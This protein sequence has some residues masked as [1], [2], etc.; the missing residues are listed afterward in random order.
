[1]ATKRFLRGPALPPRA[2]VIEGGEQRSH[3]FASLI[4]NAPLPGASGKLTNP[5]HQHPWLHGA[6]RKVGQMLGAVPFIMVRDDPAAETTRAEIGKAKTREE[7]RFLQARLTAIREASPR[8]VKD[9]I[10]AGVLRA[11]ETPVERVPKSPFQALFD[12]VNPEWSRLELFQA[13]VIWLLLEGNTVWILTGKGSSLGET[14]V[15]REIW[16][17][18]REGWKV[19]NDEKTGEV[20]EWVRTVKRGAVVE[21]QR[22]QPHE[23]IHFRAFDPDVPFFS[24]SPLKAAWSSMEQDTMAS[25]WNRSYFEN[26]AEPGVT[27]LLPKEDKS[28]DKDIATMR[29][30]WEDRHEGPGKRNRLAILTGGATLD[31]PPATHKDMEFATLLDKNR[32]AILA[33]IGVHKA[34]LGVTDSLNRATIEEANRMIWSN[35]LAPTAAYIEDRLYTGLFSRFDGGKTYG[36]F[37]LSAVRELQ[38]DLGTK[39]DTALKYQEL[40]VPLN[41]ANRLLQLGLPDYP[42]GD[43]VLVDMGKVPIEDV[44]DPLGPMGAGGNA[45]AAADD[46]GDDAATIDEDGAGGGNA[47]AAAGATL[48]GVQIE[49]AQNVIANLIAGQIPDSVAIELLVALGFPRDRAE[50]MVA[51]AASFEPADKPSEGAPPPPPPKGDKGEDAGSDGEDDEG[52]AVRRAVE[53]TKRPDRRKWWDAWWRAVGAKPEHALSMAMKAY[54]Y[55]L[56]KEQLGRLAKH[57]GARAS[58]DTLLSEADVDK[59]LFDL[60][61]AGERMIRTAEPHW[62]DA[63]ER[64]LGRLTKEIGELNFNLTDPAWERF[65]EIKRVKVVA[66]P[67][68]AREFIRETMMKGVREGRTVA[69]IQEDLKGAFGRLAQPARRLTIARTEIAQASNGVRFLGMRANDVGTVSWVSAGDDHVRESHNDFE[70]LGVVPLGTNFLELAGRGGV[71][72]SPSDPNGPPEEIINCRCTLVAE[73]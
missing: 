60:K 26:G 40:G 24:R 54:W 34:A 11:A 47:A 50:L 58:G 57:R 36:I 20:K 49:A 63:A 7:M 13:T 48:T 16:P 42:W 65:L 52:R 18:K 2:R 29:R 19:V 69:Q 44:R 28:Q 17:T 67:E 37:D 31:R 9:Y 23:I 68:A 39:A 46:E 41:D 62:K 3:D 25:E 10:S 71:L 1:M 61:P 35:L 45:G 8:R 12:T 4:R 64:S 53:V 70:A 51:D 43:M 5:Y 59:I 21:E 38:E 33:A 30:Q 27:V 32:D 22:F 15:P 73:D 66:V 72:Q 14:E 55:A 6:L 56:R